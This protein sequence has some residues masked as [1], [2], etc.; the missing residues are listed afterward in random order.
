LTAVRFV[1]E[2]SYYALIHI[3]RQEQQKLLRDIITWLR[4]GGLLVAAMGT[5]ATQAELDDL[6]GAP[7]YWGGF[8]SATNRQ[9]AKEAG[10]HIISAREETA[11]EFDE[12]VT[13]LW[14]VAQKPESD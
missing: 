2:Y 10:L 7:M 12:P 6:L 14:V 8:D 4:P 3:P 13:F 1:A 5:Q 9:L 11:E